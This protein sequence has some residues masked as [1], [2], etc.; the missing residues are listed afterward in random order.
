MDRDN[1]KSLVTRQKVESQNGCYKKSK[2][3]KFSGNKENSGTRA[4]AYQEVK[5][6]EFF[7]KFGALFFS[8]N[9]RFE[10]R[11]FALLPT[12]SL[13]NNHLLLSAL[14]YSSMNLIQSKYGKGKNLSY[15]FKSLYYQKT[16]A[17]VMQTQNNCPIRF[18]GVYLSL[19]NINDT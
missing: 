11:P 1:T 7:G 19:I 18:L 3:A 4:C 6:Q 14:I 12:K 8:C 17:L 9:H 5:R 10:V 16:F 15:Q 2:H 13:C